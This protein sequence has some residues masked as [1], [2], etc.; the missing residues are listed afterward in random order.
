MIE[1]YLKGEMDDECYEYKMRENKDQHS[2]RPSNKRCVL[3]TDK[4][5]KCSEGEY[6]K[7][8]VS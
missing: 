1:A 4:V 8:H 5:D 7:D 2:G 6:K 3:C